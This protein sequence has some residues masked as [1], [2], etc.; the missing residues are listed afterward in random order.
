[1]ADIFISYKR[2]DQE[3][4]GRV[5][6]IAEALT[7]EG[8]DVF[9]DVHVPPGS[10][11][12]EVLQSKIN[13]ARAVLVLWSHHS[14]DSDWVKE[15]AEMAKHAG[16]LI[17]VF[18]DA[19]APPFGFARIEGANL[20]DWNGDLQNMEWRNLVAAVKAKI[21][22]GEKAPTPSV[23]RVSYAP[24]KTVT[25][26]KTQ[27][28]GGGGFVKGVLTVALLGLLAGGGYFVWNMQQSGSSR[29]LATVTDAAAVAVDSATPAPSTTPPPPPAQPG[30]L[31]IASLSLGSTTVETGNE[32]R[33]RLTVENSGEQA[34]GNEGLF[35]D[36]VLSRDTSAPTRL[37]AFNS[38][39]SEDALLRGG[40]S[41]SVPALAAGQSH[42]WTETVE[43]PAGWPAG[44]FHIC[45]VVD[46][47]SKID[48]RNEADNVACTPVTLRAPAGP[49]GGAAP[50]GSTFDVKDISFKVTGFTPTTPQIDVDRQRLSISFDYANRSGRALQLKVQPNYSGP[51]TCRWNGSGVPETLSVGQ[52]GN[53][54][55][56]FGFTGDCE[57]KT[58]DHIRFWSASPGTT[59]DWA[60]HDLPINRPMN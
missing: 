14:V 5:R 29:P 50:V 33:V 36:F 43:V 49:S 23:T 9:Y 22:A 8:Y 20:A 6:P 60:A 42:T 44:R 16:K 38:T 15:E 32:V 34:L 48:E 1:M 24:S 35:T 55:A 59:S 37:L 17:P 39:W 2:E 47:G 51:G 13:A 11:W 3:E 7:A 31:S 18:L 56:S 57:E 21:G 52:S 4:L 28:S 45:A 10:S 26:T 30:N 46:S 27:K 58:L 54:T 53:A 41:S 40:R 25:I 12:E 19:V